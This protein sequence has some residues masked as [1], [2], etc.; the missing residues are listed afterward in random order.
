MLPMQISVPMLRAPVATLFPVTVTT[1][2]LLRRNNPKSIRGP[3]VLAV[4]Y[5]TLHQRLHQRRQ[6][7]FAQ[8]RKRTQFNPHGAPGESILPY[9]PQRPVQE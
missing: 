8:L 5:S 9:L 1:H 3:A 6:A 7:A 4:Q 2:G